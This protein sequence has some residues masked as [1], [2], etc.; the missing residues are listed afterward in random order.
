MEDAVT[1]TI[2]PS[3]RRDANKQKTFQTPTLELSLRDVEL[4][5]AKTTKSLDKIYKDAPEPKYLWLYKGSCLIS[6]FKDLV[7]KLMN[8]WKP[9]S[10][11]EDKNFFSTFSSAL[12]ELDAI[13][14]VEGQ[15]DLLGICSGNQQVCA[16]A[17]G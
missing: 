1:S 8:K 5:K 4:Q 14:R 16:S 3:T 17:L 13:Q 6:G 15:P 9:C 12:L 10:Y 2:Y 7:V 11:I